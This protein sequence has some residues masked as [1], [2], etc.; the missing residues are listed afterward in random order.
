MA[1]YILVGGRLSF[2]HYPSPTATRWVLRDKNVAPPVIW[3][4]PSQVEG[5]ENI[6]MQPIEAVQVVKPFA[7]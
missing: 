5:I 2:G 4:L 1:A 7:P 3:P 6:G